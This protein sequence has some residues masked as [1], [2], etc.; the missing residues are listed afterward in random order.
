MAFLQGNTYLL[1]VQILDCDDNVILGGQV[2][3]GVFTFGDLDKFYG[4]NGDVLWNEDIKSFVVPL[5]EEETFEFKGLVK[6]QGRVLMKDGSVNGSVPTTEYVYDSINTTRLSAS[7]EIGEESGKILKI[8]L[9]STSVGG[10]TSDYNEL[11][12]KPSINGVELVGDKTTEE[13]GIVS[14]EIDPTVPQHVKNIS[15][16]DINSWNS[17]SEFSGAYADLTGRPTK[18]SKFENDAGY[19]TETELNDK[20]YAT[21]VEVENAVKDKATTS[22]V[23]TKVADLVNSAPETL[24]TLGEVAQ[25]IAEN[26]SVVDALNSAIGSKA[27]QE[28]LTALDE[29]VTTLES[30]GGGSGGSVDLSNY[31]TKEEVNNL[32]PK[33][34][35]TQL[36]DGS[37]SLTI[38][39]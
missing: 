13:L 14:E 11:E 29:R 15:Q 26:E 3:K 4:E 30:S 16:S 32:I 38:G 23:D 7:F 31:Y 37:Y 17:K 5:T 8:R 24:D 19:I 35:A 9:M 2:E 6:Y 12:N 1:P 21:T 34:T 39:G 33:F 36:E 20:G 18:V 10:G 25:A 27:N 28:D 22:Y